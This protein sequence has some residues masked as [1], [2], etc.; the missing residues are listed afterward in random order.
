MTRIA[1]PCFAIRDDDT[2]FFT[3]PDVLDAV[4]GP[5]WGKVPISLATVPFS[6]PE[7][8]GKSFNPAYSADSEMPLGENKLLT[9]WLIKKIKSDQVEIMLHGYNHAYRKISGHWVGEYGWKPPAQIVKE[10]KRG[11]AY[12]ESLLD[13]KVRV[14]VPPSN[15]I[16]KTG[17]QA[18]RMANLNL[19]GIMGKGG[20]RPFTADY[21]PAYAKRWAWR[22]LHGDAYPFPLR[23]GGHTELRAYALTPRADSDQLVRS[24]EH[25]ARIHAPF[26][27]AT[28]YWE[29]SEYPEM[30]KT[31]SRLIL[32][33]DKL[34]MTFAPVSNC[35]EE[36]R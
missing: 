17:I 10:T 2:S 36:K 3:N 33:A 5:Y 23:Y 27:L 25:C 24:L 8:R 1:S 29:F 31:M 22:F 35:F 26:V 21:L 20:D 11:K 32:L 19:S 7:H 16:G 12:L 14:F 6:G 9:E 30:H 18:L 28:H 34:K 15:T 13:T 4:Y